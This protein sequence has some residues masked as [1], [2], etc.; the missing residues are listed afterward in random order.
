MLLFDIWCMSAI[1]RWQDSGRVGQEY[2]EEFTRS[3]VV[4]SGGREMKH[5]LVSSQRGFPVESYTRATA[6]ENIASPSGPIWRIVEE[7]GDE[8][9]TQ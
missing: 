1:Y 7:G 9:G 4:Q 5:D 2:V 3:K 6:G 8:V